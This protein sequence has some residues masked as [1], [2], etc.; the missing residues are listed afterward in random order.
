MTY[1]LNKTDYYNQNKNIYVL[2]CTK[3]LTNDLILWLNYGVKVKH[4]GESLGWKYYILFPLCLIDNKKL[5]GYTGESYNLS[6]GLKKNVSAAWEQS[7][8]DS[9]NYVEILMKHINDVEK[10]KC[11]LIFQKEE[12]YINT[13]YPYQY[14]NINKYNINNGESIMN[15]LFLSVIVYLL[16][17][18]ILIISNHSI[19]IIITTLLL[20]LIWFISLIVSID[21][22]KLAYKK[23]ETIYVEKSFIEFSNIIKQI[24]KNKKYIIESNECYKRQLKIKLESDKVIIYTNNTTA[25]E[26]YFNKNKKIIINK[27]NNINTIHLI[28]LYLIIKEYYKYV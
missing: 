15:V 28:E 25:L 22:L 20:L 14:C 12:S 8:I 23:V 24:S 17:S 13:N 26:M 4:I 9:Y 10:G 18:L 5:Y 19:Y 16:L 1:H 7:I 3:E 2:L 11:N 21:K 27:K 6:L